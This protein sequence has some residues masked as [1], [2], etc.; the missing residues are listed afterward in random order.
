MQLTECEKE[1]LMNSTEFIDF[2]MNEFHRTIDY[3]SIQECAEFAF[4][5]LDAAI[6]DYFNKNP[7]RSSKTK[8][9]AA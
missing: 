5:N 8:T 9:V 4:G 1:K 2:V 3:A 6:K 7:N